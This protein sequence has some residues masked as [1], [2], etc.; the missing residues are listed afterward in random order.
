MDKEEKRRQRR[1]CPRDKTASSGRRIDV[2]CCARVTADI[3]GHSIRSQSTD[4]QQGRSQAGDSRS[5][6][7]L[8]GSKQPQRSGEQPEKKGAATMTKTKKT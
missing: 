7:S 1:V 8:Q 3:D 6:H 5:S 4:D 2:R